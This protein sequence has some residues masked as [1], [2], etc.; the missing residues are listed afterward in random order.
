MWL[1]DVPKEL[2]F[3]PPLHVLESWAQIVQVPAHSFLLDDAELEVQA[4]LESFWAAEYFVPAS[5]EDLAR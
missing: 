3:S 1:R 2:Q 4:E 5:W